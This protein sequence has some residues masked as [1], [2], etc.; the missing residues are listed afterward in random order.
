MS[1]INLYHL[2]IPSTATN[3][4]RTRDRKGPSVRRAPMRFFSAHLT[5]REPHLA[6]RQGVSGRCYLD[7]CAKPPI[8]PISDLALWHKHQTSTQQR[9]SFRGHSSLS[10]DITNNK[11]GPASQ[12]THSNLTAARAPQAHEKTRNVAEGR[13]HSRSRRTPRLGDPGIMRGQNRN[14]SACGEK[15][16][17]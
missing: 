16:Q 7:D 2:S 1:F 12:D 8:S 15:K 14:S 5:S 11:H 6:L 4:Y 10:S 17:R 3:P 13:S 9:R